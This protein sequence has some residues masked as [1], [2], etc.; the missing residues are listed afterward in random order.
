MSDND[1]EVVA[2]GRY[3]AVSTYF[4]FA[5]RDGANA[6]RGN[7]LATQLTD[8]ESAKASEVLLRRVR[9]SGRAPREAESQVRNGLGIDWQPRAR[10]LFVHLDP[11]WAC[12]SRVDGTSIAHPP[13]QRQCIWP[14][15]M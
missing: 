3:F 9:V 1:I 14:L 4:A 15:R 6:K 13:Q 7:S 8:K 5:Y 11:V 2:A 10:R 12:F